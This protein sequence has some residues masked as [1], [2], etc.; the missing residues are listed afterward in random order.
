MRTQPTY[1]AWHVSHG[2]L[3]QLDIGN[4]L[5]GLIDRLESRLDQLTS[6]LTEL[7]AIATGKILFQL[8]Q[9]HEM[10]CVVSSERQFNI[11]GV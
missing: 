8:T 1:V 10:L 9:V 6:N 7:S 5:E 11:S 4:A 3:L 2:P